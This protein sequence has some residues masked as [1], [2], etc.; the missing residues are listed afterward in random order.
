MG[1]TQEAILR[2]LQYHIQILCIEAMLDLINVM[3]LMIT[4][5]MYN[6]ESLWSNFGV[7]SWLSMTT[8]LCLG[9]DGIWIVWKGVTSVG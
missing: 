5:V 9:I 2:E 4:V 1:P 6:L 3:T 7:C 8:W